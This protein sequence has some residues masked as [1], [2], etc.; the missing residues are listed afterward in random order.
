MAF[1]GACVK[2]SELRMALKIRL[3]TDVSF[4]VRLHECMCLFFQEET[5]CVSLSC[6]DKSLALQCAQL[7]A[8]DVASIAEACCAAQRVCEAESLISLGARRGIHPQPT[9]NERAANHAN[10]FY[11][12]LLA[13]MFPR[14]SLPLI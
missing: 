9:I 1:S 14:G 7:F 2:F 3:L 8:G 4:M 11:W 12:F 13:F 5:V 10:Q 6:R